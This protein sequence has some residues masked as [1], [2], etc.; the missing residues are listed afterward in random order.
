MKLNPESQFRPNLKN[1]SAILQHYSLALE[2]FNL[3]TSGIENCTAFIK[4][5]KG[6]YVLRIYRQDK[7]TAAE[8][9]LEISFVRHL[10]KHGI[11]V[12]V[13][14]NNQ[15]GDPV[16]QLY[17]ND[18]I[19]H[20]ILMPHMDGEHPEV[21][22][23]TLI[24]SL[25]VI[26]AK[27]HLLAKDY[28]HTID[29]YIKTKELREGHFIRLIKNRGSLDCHRAGFI[30]R[31]ESFIVRI[32]EKLPSRL[33]HLDYDKENVLV[34]GDKITAVLDFDDLEYAPFVRCLAYSAWDVL[35]DKDMSAMYKYI[36]YYEQVR[37]LNSTEQVI[38]PSI[39]LFRHYAIGSMDIA[40]DQ[41]NDS[42]FTRYIELESKLMA[43]I[44]EK[45]KI[46]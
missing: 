12:A 15:A 36:A 32:D 18:K 28:S 41:M 3:A 11:P 23:D 29:N 14:V 33:C 16:T 19:W 24:N 44:S 8:I 45:H 40:T 37:K 22:S 5:N 39:I 7:K 25:A 1:L 4:T 9:Q 17:E 13:P 30:D 2:K 10:H 26:Q 20:A 42:L 6:R 21:Y 31:A 27:M 43:V 46:G 35:F 34:D 38:L